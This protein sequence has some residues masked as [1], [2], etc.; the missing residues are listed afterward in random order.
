MIPFATFYATL[1]PSSRCSSFFLRQRWKEEEKKERGK[2]TPLLFAHLV[3][4]FIASLPH[5]ATD[6]KSAIKIELSTQDTHHYQYYA[7][8][9]VNFCFPSWFYRVGG[10][11]GPRMNFLSV[12]S[13]EMSQLFIFCE[14]CQRNAF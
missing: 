14:V 8:K 11:L 7:R 5:F 9:K 10:H 3:F 6:R 12:V 2:K 4:L 1:S 13:L